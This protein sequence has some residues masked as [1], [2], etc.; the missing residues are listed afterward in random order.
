[1]AENAEFSLWRYSSTVKAYDISDT[2]HLLSTAST[3]LA[4][5]VFVFPPH[6]SASYTARANDP[7]TLVTHFGATYACPL[8]AHATFAAHFISFYN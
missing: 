5:V 3:D 4:E 6:F 7:E 1:M 8:S 2:Y